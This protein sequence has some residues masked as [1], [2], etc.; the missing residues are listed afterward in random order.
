M[1]ILRCNVDYSEDLR[2]HVSRPLHETHAGIV[3]IKY[4]ARSHCEWFR[5]GKCLERIGTE[6]NMCNQ[7]LKELANIMLQQRPIPSKPRQR[8]YINDG[9]F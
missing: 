3:K 7:M 6:C 4:E 8:L 2:L 9:P 5:K 1:H